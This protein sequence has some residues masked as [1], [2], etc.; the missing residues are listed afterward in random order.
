VEVCPTHAIRA[1]TAINA[2]GY[3]LPEEEEM[4]RCTG[5]RLCE[6]VCPDFAIAIETDANEG[7]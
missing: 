3:L 7:E 4:R 1:C 5:C 2:K 6:T